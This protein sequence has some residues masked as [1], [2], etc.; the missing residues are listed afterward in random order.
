MTMTMTTTTTRMGTVMRIAT[1]RGRK[2]GKSRSGGRAEVLG[3]GGRRSAKVSVTANM[4]SLAVGCDALTVVHHQT[5]ANKAVGKREES[6]DEE[7]CGRGRGRGR[8]DGCGRVRI[9]RIWSDAG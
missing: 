1:M 3:R 2:Q 4:M 5:K 7:V 9:S 6:R 8:G